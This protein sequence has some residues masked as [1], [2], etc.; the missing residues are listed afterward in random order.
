[1]TELL[2]KSERIIEMTYGLLEPPFE[3]NLFHFHGEFLE[4]QEKLIN[5]QV[6]LTNR[7]PLCKF[8]PHAKNPGSAPAV[9]TAAMATWYICNPFIP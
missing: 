2:P 4:N 8:E 9:L 6:K 7:S 3:T 5:N 1:M